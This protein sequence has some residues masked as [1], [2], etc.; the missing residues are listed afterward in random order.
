MSIKPFYF[1]FLNGH[2]AAL[3]PFPLQTLHLYILLILSFPNLPRYFG[4]IFDC[5][6]IGLPGFGRNDG[7]PSKPFCYRPSYPSNKDLNKF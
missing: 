3:C 4:T 5:F 2:V 1:L 6:V 7:E